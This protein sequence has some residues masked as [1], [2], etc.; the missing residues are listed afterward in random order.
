MRRRFEFL[1]DNQSGMALVIALILMVVLTLI[2]LAS[3]LSSTYEIRLSGNKRGATDAFYSADSGVQVAIANIEN[4]DLPGKYDAN[5]KYHYSENP[6]NQNPAKN[7]TGADIVMYYD[8]TRTDCPPGH[9]LSMKEDQYICRHYLIDSTGQDQIELNP[10]RSS[11]E[12]EESVV[13]LTPPAQW[14]GN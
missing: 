10:L 2:G 1:T 8:P 11:C 4:F 14:G 6:A 12:I 13:R 3:T 7:P 5:S 9:G